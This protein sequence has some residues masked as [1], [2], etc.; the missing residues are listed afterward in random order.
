MI[1]EAM[2]LGQQPPPLPFPFE[3]LY[4]ALTPYPV[5][6]PVIEPPSYVDK[7][8]PYSTL[9]RPETTRQTVGDAY[10]HEPEA[11]MSSA[12]APE[13]VVGECAAPPYSS[14]ACADVTGETRSCCELGACACHNG[15]A[16]AINTGGE[17]SRTEIE[18]GYELR[19]G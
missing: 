14:G 12:T 10:L 7:P 9:F 19:H 5:P 1:L 15:S 11:G 2:E 17:T 8:P 4:N 18:T 13:V 16:Y 3:E 6:G